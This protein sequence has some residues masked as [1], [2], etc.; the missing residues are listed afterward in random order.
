[1]KIEELRLTDEEIDKIA[2][3]AKD[4]GLV[5]GWDLQ[6]TMDTMVDRFLK[7]QIQKLADK[8]YGIMEYDHDFPTNSRFVSLKEI[9][10][11]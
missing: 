6:K 3:R 1:M 4:E 9:M 8:G 10:E 5:Y 11:E 7:A 2:N